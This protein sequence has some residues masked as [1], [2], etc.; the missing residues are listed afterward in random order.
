MRRENRYAWKIKSLQMN[1]FAGF[2]TLRLSQLA[3]QSVEVWI[4]SPSFSTSTIM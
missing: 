4:P 1:D 2:F 3:D